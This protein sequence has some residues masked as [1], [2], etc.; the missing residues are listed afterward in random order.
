MAYIAKIVQFHLDRYWSW[1]CHCP[2]AWSLSWCFA[3]ATNHGEQS[4]DADAG[5]H[6][7]SLRACFG[8]CCS[9]V[10]VS[11]GYCAQGCFAWLFDIV[12]LGMFT[13]FL[14]NSYTYILA[15]RQ[16]TL[17]SY[18]L[19]AMVQQRVLDCTSKMFRLRRIQPWTRLNMS[20]MYYMW[21]WLRLW[22]RHWLISVY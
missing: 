11:R 21:V 5:R 14:P 22:Q 13:V 7:C 10:C 19:Y 18:S 8:I 20:W 3:P 17:A 2:G 15:A 6:D 16:S 1:N 12:G 4:R 9:A